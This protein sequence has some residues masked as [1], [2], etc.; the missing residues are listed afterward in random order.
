MTLAVAA[1]SG[2]VEFVGEDPDLDAA[3]AEADQAL[4][5]YQAKAGHISGTV[6]R[7]DGTV[8][9]GARVDLATVGQ[10]KTDDSGRFSFLDLTPGTYALAVEATDYLSTRL[11]VD[12]LAGQFTRPDVRLEAI[13]APEPYHTVHRLD[14][15]TQVNALGSSLLGCSCTL[16]G[17]F[18][19]E[20]LVE[21]LL[22][23]TVDHESTGLSAGYSFNWDFTASS[24]DDSSNAYGYE[25]S[26]MRVSIPADELE[27]DAESFYAS[28]QPEANLIGLSQ[29]FTAIVTVF[30]HE[31]AA[32]DYTGLDAE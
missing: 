8:L 11:D 16:E 10:L 3:A 15:Y 32:E 26:P 29:S 17:A 13:P 22:E 9:A 20:G 31:G 21:V 24:E 23:A 27:A 25:M 30:Y 4:A 7:A 14:G 1:F 28:F 2:C 5:D 18:D 12:V 6:S 19:D